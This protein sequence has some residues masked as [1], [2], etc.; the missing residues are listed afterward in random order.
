MNEPLFDF[1]TEKLRELGCEVMNPAELT[2]EL[3]GSIEKLA[4][5][6]RRRGRSVRG[7]DQG[8]D[9]DLPERPSGTDATGVGAEPWGHCEGQWPWRSISRCEAIPC[10]RHAAN[11]EW[12]QLTL[13]CWA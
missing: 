3:F 7:P 10:C 6:D 1:M 9:L 2:R 5:L 12:Q 8:A 13:S 4:K 11:A